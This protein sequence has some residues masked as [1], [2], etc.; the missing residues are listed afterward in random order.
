[1]S[2]KKIMV[3]G[4]G[5]AG[6]EAAR[7]IIDLGY[8]LVLVE[9]REELGGTPI[10]ASYAALTPDME[11]TETAMA[12]MIDAVMNDSLADIRL[13]S[14]ITSAE[15]AAPDLRVTLEKGGD[16][17]VVEVGAVI[18]ATGFKHFDP[19][20]ETQRYGYYEYDDVITLVDAEKMLK[21]GKFIRPSTG[22][23]PEQV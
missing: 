10:S 7:G 13:G 3:I 18:V 22:K 14:S 16:S 15:G 6:L 8:E 20:K 17:E 1:M 23:P 19:G 12:R 11:D 9:Q 21:A 2:N 4:G 5:P